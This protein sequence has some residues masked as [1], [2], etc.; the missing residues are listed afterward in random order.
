MA[1]AKRSAREIESLD[2]DHELVP[3]FIP[4]R[5][6]VV[7]GKPVKYENQVPCIIVE[8]GP[9]PLTVKEQVP[10]LALPAPRLPSQV[11]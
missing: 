9:R 8:R 2:R 6:R 3:Q 4:I 11:L 5:P 10:F 7:T 1:D